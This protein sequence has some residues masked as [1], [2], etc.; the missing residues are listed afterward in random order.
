MKS[1]MP[2]RAATVALATVV[3]LGA[4]GADADATPIELQ[5]SFD[6]PNPAPS[7]LFGH[8]ISLSGGI[9][10]VGAFNDG[11]AGSGSGQAYVIDTATGALL[12]TLANPAP[13]LNNFFGQSVS[14]SG[15][16]ALV[17]A[18]NNDLG[19]VNS[20][21][22]YLF[23]ATTGS[24]VRT[25]LNPTPTLFGN[26]GQSVAISGNRALISAI[27]NKAGATTSAGAA[28]LFDTDTGALLQTFPNPTPARSDQY[29]ISVALSGTMALIGAQFDD[30][31]ASNAGAAYLFDTT[32]GTLLH[33][34]LNPT[35]AVND[36]FGAAV[37]LSATKALIGSM[38]D[39]TSN[40]NA[41]AA[42]L[43]D[44]ATG[45]LLQ[46]L[47]VPTLAGDGEFLG[48]S[49]ALSDD[50]ALLGAG[51]DNTAH[52]EAGG[53]YLFDADTGALLQEIFDPEPAGGD[54]FGSAVALDGSEALIGA[55]GNRIGNAP[56]GTVF[57]YAPAAVAV[58]EPATLL[59]LG[60]GLTGLGMARRSRRRSQAPAR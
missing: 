32:T 13:G 7:T 12:H 36:T 21:A 22:A 19:A 3:A 60:V 16:R 2:M 29:G 27:G 14:L 48:Q 39:D 8:A 37:A 10:L 52:P 50:F 42:Y 56:I 25:F 4:G 59:L 33:T 6:S 57:V 38:Q 15:T 23:D 51:F 58:H 28:Y 24:L 40:F 45:D 1:K 46:T 30:T 34:F 43:Y 41:G 44:A 31:G 55:S 20:G 35:P 11:T 49:V 54:G 9:A 26:F 17:G 53:A 18:Q 47:L 5:G